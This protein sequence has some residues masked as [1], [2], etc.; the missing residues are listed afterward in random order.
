VI[1][2]ACAVFVVA[3]LGATASAQSTY[4]DS[5]AA[6]WGFAALEVGLAA[7][8]VSAVVV[9]EESSDDTDG[10]RYAFLDICLMLLTTSATAITADL[11]DAPSEG[12]LVWHGA[13]AGG[14]SLG[15]TAAGFAT[16]DGDDGGAIAGLIGGL[17]G[18]AA[19][20]AYV[21]FRADDLAHDPDLEGAAQLLTWG[22]PIAAMLLAGTILAASEGDEGSLA[23]LVAGVAAL[24]VTMLAIVL[25]ETS[26]RSTAIGPPMVT[27]SG[28]FSTSL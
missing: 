10:F 26:D 1:A 3:S 17:V 8:A 4:Q 15:L 19:M 9:S 24:A 6:S 7:S 27:E 14:L 5:T 21:G 20:G 13:I 22:P 11:T 18:V 28:L 2:R 25:A 16:L 12:P 23:A